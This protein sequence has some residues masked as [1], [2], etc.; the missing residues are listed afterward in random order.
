M[1]DHVSRTTGQKQIHYVGHSQG[2]MIGFA[3][4]SSNRTLAAMVKRFYALA[5]VAKVFNI[6]SP[7]RLL[8]PLGKIIDVSVAFGF[9]LFQNYNGHFQMLHFFL[10]QLMT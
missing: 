5:P 4:F 10:Y 8:A 3:G 2:T 6:R 7:I 9:I 1:I